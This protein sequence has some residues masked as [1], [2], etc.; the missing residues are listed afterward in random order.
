MI[1]L[2]AGGQGL[3]VSEAER[4]AAVAQFMRG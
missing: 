2:P 1:A 3:T 4:R